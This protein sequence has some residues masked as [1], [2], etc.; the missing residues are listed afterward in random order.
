MG[1]ELARLPLAALQV[2]LTLVLAELSFRIVERP[3]RRSTLRPSLLLGGWTA[4]SA[5]TALVAV[6]ILV[7]PEGR[8]LDAVDVV[9]PSTSI[10]SPTTT[11]P[12][13]SA[14]SVPAQ[15]VD[16]TVPAEPSTVLLL[17]DS[18][19]L[20]LAERRTLDPGPD[21]NIQAFARLGCSISAGNALDVGSDVGII[22]GE[23][24]E[25]W[26]TEWADAHALVEPD[27]TVVMVGAWEVLDHLVDGVAIRFPDP[28]WFDVVTAGVRESIEIASPDENLVVL[29]AVPC[30]RQ[31]PDTI[32][33]TMARNDPARLA[34]F[35]EILRQEAARDPNIHVID[36]NDRLCPGGT[37]LDEVDGAPLRYDGVHVTTEG[38][39]YVWTWLLDELRVLQEAV[40]ANGGTRSSSSPALPR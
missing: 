32:L 28:A 35:N 39:N 17:G 27:V 9:R 34:A 40:G 25:L 12:G 37:Y 26:R 6:L 16:S 14:T 1:L 23:G 18:T 3:I 10:S 11:S 38:A 31:A 19:A 20:S 15:S 2:A 8:S 30:M 22:Q 21:W 4:I 13:A 29:L 7:P 36:L 24:C 5:A 33:S